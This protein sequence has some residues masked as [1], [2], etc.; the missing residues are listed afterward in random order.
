MS[1]TAVVDR[2][3]LRIS[4]LWQEKRPNVLYALR[5]LHVT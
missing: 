3:Y 2:W 1:A 5:E 4:Y